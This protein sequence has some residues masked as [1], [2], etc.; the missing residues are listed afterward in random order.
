MSQVR[1]LANNR[2]LRTYVH[3]KEDF[4]LEPFLTLVKDVKYRNAIARFRASSH[5]LEIERGRHTNPITPE[6]NRKCWFCDSIE[7]EIHFITEC[8]YYNSERTYLYQQ[9]SNRFPYFSFLNNFEKFKFMFTFKD[10]F[11][12]TLLGK[13]IYHGF[14]KRSIL[15]RG[16]AVLS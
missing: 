1:D 14:E 15:G 7:T 16:V 6:N 4:Q 11:V 13:F 9:I 12:L 5:H 2:S 3:I 8:A 10:D